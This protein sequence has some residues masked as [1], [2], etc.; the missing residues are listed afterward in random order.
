M[1]LE[2]EVEELNGESF[3]WD[4]TANLPEGQQATIKFS[5]TNTGRTK[6]TEVTPATT[7]D[8]EVSCSVNALEPGETTECTLE[9]VV[10]GGEQEFEVTFS[11]RHGRHGMCISTYTIR[12]SGLSEAEGASK[13][14]G[15]GSL[16]GGV[17]GK[18]GELPVDAKGSGSPL[19]LLAEL[20]GGGLLKN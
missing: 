17:T 19:D 7:G 14:A 13:T 15:A 8:G 5:L 11:G 20:F 10:K 9:F 6:I 3:S 16:L 2:A 1:I 12:Y 4:D 18:I